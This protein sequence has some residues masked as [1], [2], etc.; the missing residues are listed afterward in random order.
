MPCLFLGVVHGGLAAIV[1]RVLS[2]VWFLLKWGLLAGLVALVVCVPYL[3]RQVDEQIR[4]AVEDRIAQHYRRQGVNLRVAV[5]SAQLIEGEGIELRDVSLWEGSGSR[6]RAELVHI[7]EVFVPCRTDLERLLTGKLEAKRIWLR[8]PT[9]RA[10]RQADGRWNVARLLPLPRFSQHSPEV[11]I[12]D[13]RIQV[14][15]ALRGSAAE[16]RFRDVQLR[17]V[18]QPQR[19]RGEKASAVRRFAGTLGADFLEK[20]ELTGWVHVDSGRFSLTGRL[21][22]LE[23]SPDLLAALPGSTAS[24]LAPLANLRGQVD[25]ERFSVEFDPARRPAWRFQAAGKLVHGRVDDPRLP[26]SVTDIQATFQLDQGGFRV[27]N[28]FAKSGQSTLWVKSWRRSG[29][30][31]AAPMWLEAQVRHLEIGWE[32]IDVLPE[33][34]RCRWPRYSP[35][36]TIHADVRL[37][38]DGR[39]WHP[40]LS[41]QCV[42]VG[43]TYSKFPFRLQPA[44][45]TL[46]LKNDTLTVNLVGYSGGQPVQ[47]AAELK[48]ALTEPFGWVEVRAENLALNQKL[49]DALPEKHRSLV[50]DLAPRGTINAYYRFDLPQGGRAQR[51]LQIDL[52]RCNV[53]YAR[54]PYPLSN[55]RGRLTMTNGH[56]VLSDL[57]GTN[58]TGRIYCQGR[59]NPIAEGYRFELGFTA[60]ALPLEEELREAMPS[61][62]MKRLWSALRLQG[63]ADIE[64]S[65]VY[66]TG[67]VRPSVSLRAW[68]DPEKTAIQADGFPYRLESIRGTLI[69]ANGQVR[70]EDFRAKHDDTVVSA[71]ANCWFDPDGSWQFDCQRL[72]I[73][74]LRFDRELIQALPSR[75]RY[76]VDRLQPSGPLYLRGTVRVRRGPGP[77]DPVTVRW[78]V[79]IG[80]YQASLNFGLNLENIH[81]AVHLAGGFDGTR[82][83]AG[84]RLALDAVSYRGIQL[85][86]VRGPVW[87]DEA[88]VLLGTEAARRLAPPVRTGDRRAD[89]RPVTAELFGGAAYADA[90][91]R[92]GPTPTYRVKASLSDARLSR[93]AEE[94][95]PGQQRLRGRISAGVDLSGSGGNLNNLAGVGSIRLADADIYELPLMIALLKIL[96]IKE[97]DRTA[98]SESDIRFHIDGGH[99]YLDSITF[100]GDANSLDGAGDMDFDTTIRLTFRARLGRRK[101]NLPVIQDILGGASEQIMVIHV[102]GTL[103]NPETRKEAFP[104]VNRALQRIQADLQRTAPGG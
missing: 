77:A 18:P 14:V 37:H 57:E 33:P 15:D 22:Q 75:F 97:P 103:T 25:V 85:T 65:V 7:E 24:S 54:F 9:L 50:R 69:Y 8:R 92:L 43:F 98:F 90:V 34:L 100:Q 79:E 42:S 63:A 17:F 104:G 64:G 80:L 44:R 5:R 39:R 35:S 29:Y 47:I 48:Q 76:A 32:W 21:R 19:G 55:V 82:F 102:T 70:L 51:F 91:V 89:W 68:P 101:L 73:D 10:V 23:V 60:K 72:V 45:G 46:A 87:I 94:V 3:Y 61:P 99:I 74:R 96:S 27:D 41:V 78:D 4:R 56:W 67:W 71:A 12:Q 86:D 11:V 52:N 84:G 30:T 58:D 66:Q 38:Y 59:I 53:C 36:G 49:F 40:D 28:L 13:G 81:G 1:R 31:A 62:S 26:H 88:Q 2:A 6:S 16:L 93:C 95:L 20:I 83:H